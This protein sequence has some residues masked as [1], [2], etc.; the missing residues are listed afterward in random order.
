MTSSLKTLVSG[1]EKHKQH[2]RVLFGVDP[3]RVVSVAL[4]ESQKLYIRRHN[5]ELAQRMKTQV[6]K[7]KF[8]EQARTG[9]ESKTST[10][11]ALVA[12]VQ[13]LLTA[14]SQV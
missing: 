3:L 4:P 9:S 7:S 8:A 6:L 1:K 5:E 14:I 13:V 12:A 10:Q 11:Q 2:R